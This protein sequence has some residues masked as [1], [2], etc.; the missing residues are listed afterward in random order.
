MNELL[1]EKI[2]NLINNGR[3]TVDQIKDETYKAEVQKR[4]SE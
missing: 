1:I 4:L 2:I 3:I